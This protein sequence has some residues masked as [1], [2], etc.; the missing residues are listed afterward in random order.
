[1]DLFAARLSACSERWFM[2]PSI[3]ADALWESD[4]GEGLIR[5]PKKESAELRRAVRNVGADLQVLQ[6]AATRLN[7]SGTHNEFV[8]D[9]VH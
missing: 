6:D 9:C 5:L 2:A 8:P 7:V 1:M 4:L 3:T